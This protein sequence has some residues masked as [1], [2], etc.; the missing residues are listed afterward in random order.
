MIHEECRARIV[1]AVTDK[2]GGRLN[3]Y[4]LGRATMRAEQ[5]L[6][7]VLK[8]LD[9]VD[10][11]WTDA[12]VDDARKSFAAN[13]RD[14]SKLIGGRPKEPVPDTRDLQIMV[15]AS[16]LPSTVHLFSNDVHFWGYAD[17][18]KKWWGL[19]VERASYLP[20]LLEQW[21]GST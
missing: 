20:L 6:N 12:E 14:L 19:E 21:R 2:F 18:C 16:K 11:P 1:G 3:A 4:A 5:R 7:A 9:R 8:S 15:Q 17:L 13:K 10:P